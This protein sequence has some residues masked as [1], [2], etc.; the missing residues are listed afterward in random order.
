[1]FI[2]AAE[3]EPKKWLSSSLRMSVGFVAPTALKPRMG[4]N[5]RVLVKRTSKLLLMG[6]SL[7]MAPFN[8]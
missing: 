1:M 6:K 7:G 8:S 4:R 5:R 2:C 3:R